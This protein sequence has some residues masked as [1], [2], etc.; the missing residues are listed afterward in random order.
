[1][2][3]PLLRRV[4]H[5]AVGLGSVEVFVAGLR[6]VDLRQIVFPPW[7]RQTGLCIRRLAAAC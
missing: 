1:M 6:L 5:G 4:F 3:A 2:D 7:M